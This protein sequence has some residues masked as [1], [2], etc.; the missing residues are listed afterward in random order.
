MYV[1][2]AQI[3]EITN[4]HWIR[5][6]R[7]YRLQFE[8]PKAV[9]RNNSPRDL[10]EIWHMRIGHI[11]HGELKLLLEIVVGVPNV[12]TKYD[13]VSKGCVLGKFTKSYF[14]RNETRSKVVLDLVHLDSCGQ[15]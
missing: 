15:K 2:L 8:I 11:H 12:N 4:N 5:S 6:G 1:P 13:D 3:L 7:L 9:M 10:G 14:L